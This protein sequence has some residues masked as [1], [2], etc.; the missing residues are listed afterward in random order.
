MAIVKVSV[1]V[2]KP[3]IGSTRVKGEIL[4]RGYPIVWHR[5]YW[6]TR[7]RLAAQKAL[8]RPLKKNEV[9]HHIDGNRLNYSNSNLLICTAVYHRRLHKRCLNRFGTWHLPILGRKANERNDK[10]FRALL[11]AG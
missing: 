9:V 2:P 4:Y 5:G 6:R 8:G 11:A 10:R 3:P 7:H 1:A